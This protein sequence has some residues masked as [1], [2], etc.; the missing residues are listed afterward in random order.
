MSEDENLVQVAFGAVEVK[1]GLTATQILEWARGVPHS[2]P[3]RKAYI[4]ANY[5]PRQDGCWDHLPSAARDLVDFLERELFAVDTDYRLRIAL[6][7]DCGERHYAA[8]L[9]GQR[10]L[11]REP[12]V[13]HLVA[14]ETM[15][16]RPLAL[17]FRGQSPN[18]ET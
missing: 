4:D 2:G 7:M 1:R 14:I 10:H 6:A 18:R 17:T 13:R 16:I 15:F 11:A 5:R 8:M 9:D 3:E 12:I